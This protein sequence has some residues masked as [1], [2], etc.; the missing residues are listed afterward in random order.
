MQDKKRKQDD[1]TT[2]TTTPPAM[3][4][5]KKRRANPPRAR[6][7]PQA[8]RGGKDDD[9]DSKKKKKKKKANDNEKRGRGTAP[10]L[11]FTGFIPADLPVELL[12]HLMGYL[13]RRDVIACAF[14]SKRYRTA[15][16]CRLP[17][18]TAVPAALSWIIDLLASPPNP[19]ATEIWGSDYHAY[20]LASCML[21]AVD[22]ECRVGEAH[23]RVFYT[24]ADGFP[25]KIA[26][27]STVGA[28]R[29]LL[30]HDL[31]APSDALRD[32]KPGYVL[33]PDER[34]A[35]APP[36]R[37][38]VDHLRV[39]RPAGAT[40]PW[41]GPDHSRY[42]LVVLLIPPAAGAAGP[43]SVECWGV[44]PKGGRLRVRVHFFHPDLSLQFCAAAFNASR[45]AQSKKRSEAA[46]AHAFLRIKGDDFRVIGA[47][48]SALQQEYGC[49]DE[50]EH[51]AAIAVRKRSDAVAHRPSAFPSPR[52]LYEQTL[53][54]LAR[55]VTCAESR[56]A[57]SVRIAEASGCPSE[58]GEEIRAL[59]EELRQVVALRVL[60]PVAG[61]MSIAPYM[62]K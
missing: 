25:G 10:G 57:E 29:R 6:K 41:I 49:R 45:A 16:L 55:L 53:A 27:I 35:R 54:E 23:A 12:H 9:A 15:M 59:L 26:T 56:V 13:R 28:E 46:L 30:C 2:T 50:C 40:L 39:D 42:H 7:S 47:Y 3:Q 48:S 22:A 33:A 51:L 37:G 38:G 32:G 20:L 31:V 24:L 11:R 5:S 62:K 58:R 61:E 14:L 21:N 36:D 4:G 19:K 1:T 34:I 60:R 43:P 18:K 8:R 52:E 44:A 17:W